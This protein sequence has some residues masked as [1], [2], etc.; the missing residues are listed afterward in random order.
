MGPKTVSLRR[1]ELTD[2]RD[3]HSWACLPEACRF[4]PW[5]PNTEEQTRAFVLSAVEGWAHRPQRRFAFVARY[6]GAV[7]GMGELRVRSVEHRQGELAY[8]VH[9]KLFSILEDEWRSLSSPPPAEAAAFGAGRV[10][11]GRWP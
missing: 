11:A 4:Q 7:V 1:I 3:V 5:G 9:P 2:W 10:R 6:G 8:V